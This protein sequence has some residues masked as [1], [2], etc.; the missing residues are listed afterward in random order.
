MLPYTGHAFLIGNTYIID[1]HIVYI[2]DRHT[3]TLIHYY[4]S[5]PAVLAS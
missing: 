2:Q 3:L 5:Y 4:L 1:T